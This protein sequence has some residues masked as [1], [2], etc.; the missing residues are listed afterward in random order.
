[1]CISPPRGSPT[2]GASAKKL[3]KFSRIPNLSLP[4]DISI[5]PIIPDSR[6]VVFRL[7]MYIGYRAVVD[8]KKD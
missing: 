4:N 6:G 5:G 3:A 2:V 7:F 1:M 8:F